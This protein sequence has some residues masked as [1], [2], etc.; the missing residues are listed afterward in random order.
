VWASLSS[1]AF[2]SQSELLARSQ[3]VNS[4]IVRPRPALRGAFSGP[5]ILRGLVFVALAELSLYAQLNV[6]GITGTLYDPSG[7]VMPGVTVV[8]TNTGTALSEEV[9]TSPAGAYKF[10]L[11]PI[12]YY[13]VTIAQRGFQKFERSD[14]QVVS[15]ETVSVDIK[16]SVGQ[17][18]QTITVTGTAA[19]LDTSTSNASTS[20]TSQE[21]SALPVTL[22]GNSSRTASA[23]AR[24]MAGVVYDPGESG[25]QEFMV[26]SRSQI[27]GQAAGTWGYKIDGV[28]A[29]NGDRENASDFTS[30]VPDVVQEV[31]ITSNTDV[32]DGFS[33][34]VNLSI[35]L[36]SGTNK[37]HGDLYHYIRNDLT[38]AR[39]TFLPRFPCLSP[40]VDS[41]G[42]AMGYEI[43]PGWS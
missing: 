16:L 5:T 31:Q 9:V 19:L 22:Y 1:A 13:T 25:G 3:H 2:N 17:V 41:F 7:A 24:T 11:L 29:S 8:A 37:L 14:I 18:S 39:N 35:T 4:R 36:K 32:S 40:K 10:T 21:I 15:G 34:G 38:E 23:F 33:G 20:R 26:I 43:A 6:G 28:G 42:K 30:P 27:N 12:G